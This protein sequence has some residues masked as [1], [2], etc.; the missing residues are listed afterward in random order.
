MIAALMLTAMLAII[1]IA[2]LAVAAADRRRAVRHTRAEVR[3]S[4][5]Y[6]GLTYARSYFGNNFANWNTFLANPTQFNP[7]NLPATT[8]A[9]GGAKANLSTAASIALIRTA[10]P[11]LFMDLDN[12]GLSDVYIFIR[13]NA[14]EFAPAVPNFQRDN[15]QNVIVGAVCISTTMQ[16][17]REKNVTW[18]GYSDIDA[19]RMVVESML[20][21]NTTNTNSS[22]AS[23]DGNFNNQA[24]N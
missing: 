10:Q 23:T 20:S 7:M 4:C 21:V 19:D 8:P 1:A 15:D 14:D 11:N 16:P 13:D 5:A 17:R 3:E 6:S 18:A 22:G 9:W 2:V 12:D 24:T